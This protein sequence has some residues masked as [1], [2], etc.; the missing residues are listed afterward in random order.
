[1]KLIDETIVESKNH[2]SSLHR[3]SD[4]TTSFFTVLFLGQIVLVPLSVNLILVLLTF[5]VPLTV[6]VENDGLN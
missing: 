5:L 6:L 2:T 4:A 1:M 3:T